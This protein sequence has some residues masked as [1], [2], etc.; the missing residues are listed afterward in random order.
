MRILV[1]GAGGFLGQRLT[2]YLRAAGHEPVATTRNREMA[3]ASDAHYLADALDAG[4]YGRLIAAQDIEAVV[5][6]AA[7]G[8]DPTDRDI[9]QLVR[10]NSSFPAE[11]AVAAKAAGAQSFVH[12]GSSAEYAPA[13]RASG[14]RE[15]DAPT[16]D[17]IYGATKAAGSL[18][19][20]ATAREIGLRCAIVRLFNIFGPGEKS[21]RLFPSLVDRLSRGEE[22]ALSTGTQMR[23]FLFV[24]DACRAIL[25]VLVALDA[26]PGVGGTYNLA[27]GKGLAVRDFALAIATEMAADPHLLKFGQLPMRPDDLPYVV[28]DTRRLDDLIGPAATTRLA[29]AI[30]ATLAETKRCEAP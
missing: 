2:R 28:A 4:A 17:K 25:E 27:S 5:N 15:D 21:Y 26:Q 10:A 13:V 11:L 8:V 24:D 29:D 16:R 20:E 19:L 1:T 3:A 23:D 30:A 14:M 22:V 7:A 6:L 18:L 12:A 9:P